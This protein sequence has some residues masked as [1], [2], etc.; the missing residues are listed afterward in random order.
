MAE[1][2]CDS[3]GLEVGVEMC[4]RQG[5]LLECRQIKWLALLAGVV[6]SD[7]QLFLIIYPLRRRDCAA[8]VLAASLTEARRLLLKSADRLYPFLPTYSP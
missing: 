8:A 4:D 3:T 5:S 6:A 2:G 1:A 7:T